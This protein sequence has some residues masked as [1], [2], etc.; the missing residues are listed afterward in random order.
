MSIQSDIR[1]T[2]NVSSSLRAM[3][4]QAEQLTVEMNRINAELSR[5]AGQDTQTPTQ[6]FADGV[7][8][9]ASNVDDLANKARDKAYTALKKVADISFKAVAAG[10]AAVSAQIANSVKSYADYE[11]LVGGVET[12]FG[13]GGASLEEYAKSTG[14]SVKSVQ[15]DYNKLMSAQAAVLSNADNAYKNAELSANDYMETVTSFSAS[16]ISSLGGD[17]QK[18][19][20]YADNA[21]VAMSDNANK[22][23]TD[24][25]SIQN[26]Y[27]GFAKQ[28]YTMLDNLKLGYGG[29]KEEMARLINDSKVLGDTLVTT[30]KDGNFEDVVDFAKITK[31]IQIIQDKMGISGTTAKEAATTISGS[32]N[33][34]KAAWNDFSVALTRGDNIDTAINKLVES[35]K[36]FG[37]NLIP[38]L[39]DAIKGAAEALPKLMPYIEQGA[40]QLFGT[41]AEYLPQV[42]PSITS[43]VIDM[44]TGLA[45]T[46]KDN[47]DIIIDT[48]A[49]VAT[50][51]VDALYKAITGDDLDTT[52]LNNIHDTLKDIG[53]IS[54]DNLDTLLKVILIFAALATAVSVISSIASG[55]SML[56]TVFS[57]LGTGIRLLIPI[58]ANVAM[59]IGSLL[60][61]AFMTIIPAIWSAITAVASFT[62][63]LL[64]CPITWIVIAI[65]ALIAV[66]V[67][68]ATHW[69]MVKE[70]AAKAWDKIAEV[71]GSVKDWFAEKF[72][73]VKETLASVWGNIKESIIN[74][75]TAVK[76]AIATKVSEIVTSVK[77]KFNDIVTSVKQQASKF[78]TAGRDMIDGLVKGIVE[79]K[80]KVIEKIKEICKG[81]LDAVKKFFGIASPSKLMAEMGGYVSEG[82]AVGIKA[83]TPKVDDVVARLTYSV[84]GQLEQA[85]DVKPKSNIANKVLGNVTNNSIKNDTNSSKIISTSID[86]S[87]AN[88]YVNSDD[89]IEN[90]AQKL[91]NRIAYE[92]NSTG[93]GV[94]V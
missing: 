32:F 88:F 91:A 84:S 81:A 36:T 87:G 1:L 57:L 54:F 53:E 63:S 7:K 93:E 83:E 59:T 27:Q 4:T 6:K 22:M 71:W 26:A 33:M 90:I 17:T 25:E 3:T 8:K 58:I 28:N 37:K 5:F 49:T 65:V 34:A 35:V 61:R 78:I 76:T 44:I 94:F 19:A 66:I 16:L 85:K 39:E 14:K 18:A 41:I 56:W 75:W 69:D 60:L 30:G 43:A 13:A 47:S 23:G 86:M 38:A 42:V 15:A 10:V 55:V 51:I 9:V 73:A 70:Y 64:T 11:Q 89:D 29:T 82:F 77:T 80:D 45:Q 67:L 2:D 46:I 21:L 20:T 50:Q 62:V 52:T 40:S 12:L 24:M 79:K 92:L 68:L 74:T 72:E 31:A 48:A